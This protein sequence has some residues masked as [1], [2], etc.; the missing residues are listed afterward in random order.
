MYSKEFMNRKDDYDFKI[1]SFSLGDLNFKKRYNLKYAYLAGAMYR[2]ISSEEMVIKLGK[3][4]IMC[5]YGAGGLSLEN[6]ENAIRIIRQELSNNQPYSINLL[7]NPMN[8][9]REKKKIDLLIK[10]D[11]AVVDA[12]G[13]IDISLPLIKYRAQ[14]LRRGHDGGICIKN[15]IIGKIS[16]PEVAEAFLSPAPAKLIAK[17]LEQ[18]EISREQAELL[19]EIP[20]ADDICVEADSGGHTDAGS[21]YSLMPAIITLRNKIMVKYRYN[22]K[23]H[24][25]AAGGIGTPEAAA[26]AFILGADFICTGSINQCT[27]Q[28]KTSDIVKDML[29]QINVQDTDYAPSGDMFELGAKIQVVKKGLL[30]P[31]R[32]KKL[33]DL[34]QRHNSL[35]EIDSKIKNQLQKRYFKK[36]FDEILNDMTQRQSSDQKEKILKNPKQKMSLIFKWYFDYTTKIALAGTKGQEI[37]YQINCGPSLGAFNQWVKGTEFEDWRNRHVDEIGIK[38]MEETAGLLKERFYLMMDK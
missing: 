1:T 22:E 23:I 30:F 18:A 17:L 13:F 14:G 31:S 34:Y 3:S 12:A 4:G 16:R 24:V 20:V 38:L 8:P 32:A 19:R 25:G 29:Q 27:I 15:R 35:E 26:A 33:F 37:D 10:Y 28:A 36:S 7:H 5:S 21:P 2:G 6:I 11:V 9:E